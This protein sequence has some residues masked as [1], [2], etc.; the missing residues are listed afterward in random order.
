MLTKKLY[1]HYDT[2][3]ASYLTRRRST[4][5]K[6]K[7]VSTKL[8]HFKALTY[9]P[10]PLTL[11][12]QKMLVAALLPIISGFEISFRFVIFLPLHNHDTSM[13]SSLIWEIFSSRSAKTRFFG[14]TKT[15][16]R[17]QREL[18]NIAT[19]NKDPYLFHGKTLKVI[20]WN[21]QN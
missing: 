14:Y 10:W 17:L 19:K 18:W 5:C 15:R 21:I 3:L 6:R 9:L 8:K 16:T 7:Q 13:S 4:N 1:Q 2:Q 12:L 11:C 20:E